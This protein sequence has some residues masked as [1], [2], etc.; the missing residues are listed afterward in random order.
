MKKPL[1]ID[2]LF[3]AWVDMFNTIDDVIE[4]IVKEHPKY[5]NK[6]NRSAIKK[7]IQ[8]TKLLA[9]VLEEGKKRSKLSSL[10]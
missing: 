8:K 10:Q 1:I 2:E 7:E 5:K 3:D 9:S 6:I 4:D